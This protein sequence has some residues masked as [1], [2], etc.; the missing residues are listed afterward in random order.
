MPREA[1][2]LPV[3]TNTDSWNGILGSVCG[4][5]GQLRALAPEVGERESS[6]RR[7]GALADRTIRVYVNLIHMQTVQ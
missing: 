2:A 5:G 1:F 3:G 6:S 4:R 7:A